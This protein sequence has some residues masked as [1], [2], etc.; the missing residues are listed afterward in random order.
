MRIGMPLAWA[1]ALSLF[2]STALADDKQVCA[3][4]YEKSQSLRDDGKLLK[5]REQLR[6]CARA[7]CPDAIAKTCAE[8]LTQIEQRLPSIVLS[9]KNGSGA[10]LVDV[11]VTMDGADLT[12]KLEGR[13]VEVDPGAHTFVFEGADGRVEQQFVV[14][15][16]AKDQALAVTLGK[17]AVPPLADAQPSTSEPAPSPSGGTSTLR[18]VGYG[19]GGLGLVGLGLGV[20]FGLQANSKFDESKK[21]PNG[22]GCDA[23]DFC[24]AQGKQARSDAQSAGTLSTVGFVAGGV[25]LATGVALVVFAPSSSKSSVQT[26]RLAPM[27]GANAGGIMIGGRFQ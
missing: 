15:Q 23:N 2:G 24:G 25:L 22:T 6:L 20:I 26:A 11:R 27:V 21:D 9:A 7:E 1:A 8:W 14:K 17:P 16:G 5:S 3:D 10:D 12:S 18:Y 4:A 13:A 19:V